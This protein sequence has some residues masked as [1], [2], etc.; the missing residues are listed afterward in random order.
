MWN[1]LSY[2]LNQFRF[3]HRQTPPGTKSQASA[4]IVKPEDQRAKAVARFCPLRPT[5]R[6]PIL[7]PERARSITAHFPQRRVRVSALQLTGGRR[8]PIPSAL[9][10]HI[11]RGDL[12]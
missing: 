12:W 6:M 8:F 5:K 10:F 1:L 3:D 9:P 4:E 2:T 11:R 7:S